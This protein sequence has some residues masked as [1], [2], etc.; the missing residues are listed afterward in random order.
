MD[1]GTAAVGRVMIGDN[2]SGRTYQSFFD[3]VVASQAPIA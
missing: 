3:D 2:V 1:L